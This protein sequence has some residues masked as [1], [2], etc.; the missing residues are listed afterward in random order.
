VTLAASDLRSRARAIRPRAYA[1]ELTKACNL[2]CGYCYYA[3]RKE[4]YAP[5]ER[6]SPETAEAAILS[7]FAESDPK[8]PLHVHFFGG[9]PLLVPELLAHAAAF[10]E[11]EA[12]SRGR[13][14]SFEVTTNGTR[15]TD[16]TIALLNRHRMQVG[17]SL[18]GPP[19]IQDAA[20][21][22]VAGGG[23]AAHIQLGLE[24]FLASRSGTPLE[25]LT[26][27]SVVI[28]RRCLDLAGI[29]RHLEGMGFRKVILT[30]ATDLA[31]SAEGLREQD[32][33]S[34]FAAL[35]DLAR[36][37]EARRTQGDTPADTFFTELLS[38][39]SSG[40]RKE[41][42][43][44]GGRDYLGVAA[45]GRA[46]LCY[47]F[48]EDEAHA[49]GDVRQGIDRTLTER[50]LA[51]PVAARS[52]C[53]RCWARH[54]CG[55][56][57]HHDNLL[58]TGRLGDPNPVTCSIFRH[59]MDRA[60]E[61]WARLSRAAGTRAPARPQMSVTP[62]LPPGFRPTRRATAHVREVQDARG[63]RERVVYEPTSH[64]IVVLNATAAYTYD[65]CD[66]TRTVDEIAALVAERW[67]APPDLV[68]ADVR[69]AL[70]EFRRKGLLED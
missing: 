43:C 18:D 2:R 5:S 64:E 60:L 19:E 35:D 39:I 4:A 26:H 29:V 69:E 7:L 11:E 28:T 6:M 62:P 46:Y 49:M 45:D 14:V 31:G 23:S 10:A 34:V 65:L 17:V 30:P 61:M 13:T 52:A 42:F 37:H 9:E 1:L 12:R 56:G 70:S 53:G 67:R 22:H 3:Q 41:A 16:A 48:F 40:Q 55:G 50:L 38:A 20:R 21:P 27:A 66:G 25:H 63:R 58:A 59:G 32:L 54:F 15:F 44:G 57:C 33:P 68:G 24:R 51:D 8:D 47:R 36:D